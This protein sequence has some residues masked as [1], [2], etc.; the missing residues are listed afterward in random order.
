MMINR[1][2]EWTPS[3]EVFFF[4]CVKLIYLGTSENSKKMKNCL[5]SGQF[6]PRGHE[7]GPSLFI[8]NNICLGEQFYAWYIEMFSATW[9]D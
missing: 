5:D 7:N 3:T 6:F 2:L 4:T 9:K 8:Q 1:A